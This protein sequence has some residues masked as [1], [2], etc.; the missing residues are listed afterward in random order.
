[1]R[2]EAARTTTLAALFVWL[3]ILLPLILPHVMMM[4]PGS[5]VCMLLTVVEAVSYPRDGALRA[6]GKAP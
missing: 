5:I 3:V 6:P 4:I 1:M 2:P